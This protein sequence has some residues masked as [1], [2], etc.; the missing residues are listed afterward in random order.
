M[1]VF[2]ENNVVMNIL[3]LYSKPIIAHNGGVQRVTYILAEELRKRGHKVVFFSSSYREE[4]HEVSGGFMQYYVNKNLFAEN[5]ILEKFLYVIKNNATDAVICQEPRP[6]LL[7]LLKHTPGNIKKIGCVHYRP[8]PFVGKEKYARKG[9]QNQTFK[10]K[11]ITGL[12]KITPIVYRH[13]LVRLGVDMFRNAFAVCD[14]VCLLSEKYIPLVK[15]Y[16]SDIPDEKLIAINNPNTFEVANNIDWERKEKIVLWV[17]RL[18]EAQKNVKGF[19]D[20]WK[21]VGKDNPDWTAQIVGDG[22][23][24]NMLMSYARKRKVKNLVFL[25]AQSNVS[26][27][28]SRASIFCL[29]SYYEGWP[30]VLTE[31]MAMGCVPI[32]YNTYE[33]ASDIINSGVD[34][35]VIKPFDKYEYARRIQSLIDNP[36][37]RKAMGK[38]AIVSVKRF[39]AG[40]IADKWE[41]FLKQ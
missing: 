1:E 6:D 25:G 9:I 33:A 37:Q 5:D 35:H 16:I 38:R 8:F 32:C 4:D 41:I 14:H 40:R 24:R 15:N 36:E 28:Y 17:G 7:F 31:S 2:T 20:I 21:I 13:H 34:G 11:V 29:S 22:P 12:T 30:M 26:E 27:F 23:D 3:F 10:Q 39:E 18:G 19:I